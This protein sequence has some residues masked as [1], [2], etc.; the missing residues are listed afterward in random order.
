LPCESVTYDAQ[1]SVEIS[2]GDAYEDDTGEVIFDEI[3]LPLITYDGDSTAR[4]TGLHFQELQVP[5]GATVIDARIEFTS[6]SDGFN[7]IK[8]RNYAPNTV[9]W[10]DV[11]PWTLD[12]VV[13]SPNLATLLN[14]VVNKSDWCGGKPVSFAIEG[15][16][17]RLASAY[18]RGNQ[19]AP[20]LKVEYHLD[21]LP[22]TGGC[23]LQTAQG[24]IESSDADARERRN[25]TTGEVGTTH[26]FLRVRSNWTSALSFTG[27]DVPQGAKIAS[28]KVT[29]HMQDHT[30]Q[31]IG[32]TITNVYLEADGNPATFSAVPFNI[33]NRSWTQALVWDDPY[34]NVQAILP[35]NRLHITP[36][37]SHLVESVVNQPDWAPNNRMN[38]FL[39]HASGNSRRSYDTWDRPGEVLHSLDITYE[40]Q[41]IPD[42]D[43]DN[44]GLVTGVR[45]DLINIL[46][47]FE[48]RGSTPAVGALLEAQRYFAGDPVGYGTVRVPELPDDKNPEFSRVSHPQSYTGGN[49]VIP[50]GCGLDQNAP[51]CA[52]EHINGSP[53]YISP[54]VHECQ[55]NH[56]VLLTDGVPDWDPVAA[57]QARELFGGTCALVDGD[58]E[59]YCGA[60]LANHMNSVDLNMD[61]EGTQNLTVHTIGFNLLDNTW[62]RSVSSAGG[63][64]HS[65]A[66]SRDELT[67][68][69]NSILNDVAEVSG[70]FVAPGATVD[71][72]SRPP[73]WK[74]NLKRYTIK[75]LPP[76]IFD[77]NDVEAVD[78][79]AGV[80]RDR[81]QSFW[82]AETDGNNIVKGGAA[83][84][85]DPADR[86]IVSYFGGSNTEL[87]S[88]ANEISTN[89]PLVTEALFNAD[90][91]TELA[92]MIDWL[93]GIDVRDEDR[94]SDTTELRHHLGD[95][96]HSRPQIITYSGGT[97]D[98]PESMVVFGTNDGFIHGVDTKNG[99]EEFAF[100]PHTLFANLKKLYNNIPF[101][102]SD[103]RVYGM[104]GDLTVWIKE[105]DDNG[106]ADPADTVYVY[107]GMRRGGRDYWVLDLTHTRGCW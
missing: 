35:G 36:D 90:S 62:L 57:P 15:I 65:T 84:L 91:D 70:T 63:G 94:D 18:E 2:A 41:L 89:N 58:Q 102:S 68:A 20:V 16:G 66:D 28:A 101:V 50:G 52:P 51:A 19:T 34:T 29:L 4:F 103:E 31:S 43:A 7:K 10:E 81:A 26:S 83:S 38:V 60:E 79:Q 1:S 105:E 74:G 22:A 92:Q 24:I 97:K 23:M 37:I 99:R 8:D 46:N 88:S 33:T 95:P 72:F 80:F 13:R 40:S 56:V 42:P 87:I 53:E 75:G 39:E 17:D 5:Q 32:D 73:G 30:G 86:N 67:T 11:P 78:T 104:D 44:T 85:L 3:A 98:D 100:M 25:G 9:E 27:I 69:I 47:E 21:N 49:A 54:I 55:K 45:S 64:S 77:V 82:S 61:F 48:A 14:P 12:E 107:A 96:L 106:I 6:A 71:L 76:A 59:G 93:Y